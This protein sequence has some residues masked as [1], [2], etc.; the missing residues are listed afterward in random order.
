MTPYQRSP[1]QPL[2]L[3]SI[4]DVV[5]VYTDRDRAETFARLILGEAQAFGGRARIL[6]VGCGRGLGANERTRLTSLE[7]IRAC[8]IEFWGCEPDPGIVPTSLLD[9]FERG[10]LQSAML[11]FTYFDIIYAHY[12]V[13]HVSDPSSF[14]QKVHALL[15]PGGRFIFM[16]PNA[17]H[18]FVKIARVIAAVGLETPIL[19]LL[20]P[21]AA[22]VHYPTKYL[23][24]DAD[25]VERLARE[26]GFSR[27]DFAYF[28]HGD[29]RSYFPRSLRWIPTGLERV[30]AG[31]RRPEHL[32]GLVVRLE[33]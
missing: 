5:N 15:R 33:K 2:S 22:A 13:E 7:A 10:T 25:V 1:V 17:K 14:F 12:V 9:R 3:D 18:Y 20:H 31:L 21:G 24:N 23:V 26:T 16:T 27:C 6:D 30:L 29:L 4:V 32:P 8:A 28:E 11:P 19:K